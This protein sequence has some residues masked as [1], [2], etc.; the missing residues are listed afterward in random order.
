MKVI[1][2]AIEQVTSFIDVLVFNNPF[3]LFDLA[4]FD[5]SQPSCLALWHNLQLFK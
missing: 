5:Q 4:S 2:G 3:L 1:R